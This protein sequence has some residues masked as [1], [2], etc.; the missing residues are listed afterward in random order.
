MAVKGRDRY[1]ISLYRQPNKLKII[2]T[3]LLDQLTKLKKRLKNVAVKW[4]MS[5][6]FYSGNL[7]E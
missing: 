3:S 7:K 1:L 6:K 4:E 5:T 2:Y